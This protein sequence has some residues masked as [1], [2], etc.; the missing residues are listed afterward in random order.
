MAGKELT[1]EIQTCVEVLKAGGLIL[2]PSDTLWGIGCDATDE[3]AVKKVYAL[4]GQPVGEPMVCL[5]GNDAMLERHVA[6]V[7]DLAWEITDMATKPTTV[8][9]DHPRGFAP[10]LIPADGS[11]AIRIATDKFCRYLINAY[12]NPLVS[13]TANLFGKPTP[14]HYGEIPEVILKGVDYVVN[15]QRDVRKA[16]SSSI[17]KLGNDGTVKVIRE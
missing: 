2:Y 16:T 12:K 4:K 6:Q 5:V 17:I 3:K 8:V 13:T 1:H 11:M 10:S 9:Y 15:L 14:R 7:P